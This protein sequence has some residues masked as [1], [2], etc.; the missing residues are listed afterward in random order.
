MTQLGPADTRSTSAMLLTLASLFA[1][2]AGGCMEATWPDGT[3]FDP[4]DCAEDALHKPIE[5]ELARQAAA[6]ASERCGAH[7]AAGCSM[8]GVVNELG[9]GVAAN[10]GRARSLYRSACEARNVRACGNLGELLLADLSH[11]ESP[12]GAVALL[13][14]S[15]DVGH[16]RACGVLGRAY[17]DGA[18]VVRAP[19]VAAA[20]LERACAKGDAPSCVR[21]VDLGVAPARATEL[22]TAAC[23]RGLEEGCARLDHPTRPATSGFAVS[24][25]DR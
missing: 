22:L 3:A 10:R 15:C 20:W 19:A 16:A 5:L 4:Q 12:D 23:M 18:T 6:E 8:L 25:R 11:G 21:L 17:A 1:L 13:R 2:S 7:D 24:Q 9:Q 14:T